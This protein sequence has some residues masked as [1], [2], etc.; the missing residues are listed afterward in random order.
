MIKVII[1]NKFN[2]I[3]KR[4]LIIAIIITNT[5]VY[6]PS[7]SIAASDDNDQKV[8][9][10]V[11]AAANAIISKFV[12]TKIT[13]SKA[14]AGSMIT[15]NSDTGD[16]WDS[17]TKVTSSNGTTR[18]YRNYKQYNN[19]NSYWNNWYW[20]GNISSDGCGPSSVAIVLSGY[21]YDYNP[22]DV[23]EV[24][25]SVFKTNA[26]NTFEKLMDPLKHIGNIEAEAH[27]GVGTST[28]IDIIRENFKAGRPVIVNAPGHYV[29]YLGEDANG[30]LI[31]SDPGAHDGGHARYGVTLEDLINNGNITNGYILIKSDGSATT[32]KPSSTQSTNNSNSTKEVLRWPVGSEQ[33]TTQGGKTFANGTPALGTGNVSRGGMSRGWSNEDH[34]KNGGQALDIHSNGSSNV[35]NVVAMANGKVIECGDGIADGDKEGHGGMGNYVTIDYGNG[36]EIRAMH[37]YIGTISVKTGDTVQAGQVLGKIGHSGDSS[38]AHL[39]L[40]MKKD[41]QWVD[42]SQYIAEPGVTVNSN[43][44]ATS[45]MSN[46]NMS[47]NI[48]KIEDSG[49]SGYKINIDLDKEIDDMLAKLKKKNFK[50]DSY[51]SSSKQKEYLKNMVK[52][53]IVTQYPDLRSASEIANKNSKI[54]DDE[55]QGCIKIKRYADGETEAFGGNIL[56]KTKDSQDGGIYLE[57]RPYDDF[58]KLINNG[59]RAALNYF[60]LDSSNNIVVAGWETMD[61]EISEPVQTNVDEVGAAPSTYNEK[62]VPKSNEYTKLTMKNVNYL[63]QVSNYTMPFSL[64]WSLLVYGHDENFANDVAKLVID[65]EI[66]I[67]CYDATDIRI[68]NYDITYSKV[69]IVQSTAYMPDVTSNT[70]HASTTQELPTVEVEYK[71]KA[72]EKDTLKTDNPALKVTYADTWTAVYKYDYK[73]EATTKNPDKQEVLHKDETLETNYYQYRD[74]Q[75]TGDRKPKNETVKSKLD[76][77]IEQESDQIISKQ[78]ES[79][80]KS[81]ESYNQQYEYR[82]TYIGKVIDHYYS[83]GFINGYAYS[84]LQKKEVQSY[85]INMILDRGY[86]NSVFTNENEEILKYAKEIS[87]NDYA[88]CLAEAEEAVKMILDVSSTEYDPEDETLGAGIYKEI[89]KQG[90]NRQ[91]TYNAEITSIQIAERKEKINQ[92][93]EITQ[94]ITTVEVKGIPN[95]NDNLRWKDNKNAKENSFVKILAHSKS[96]RSNLKIIDTWFF[97]SV[98]ETAAIADLSDLIRFLFEC[99]YNKDYGVSPERIEELKD[100][101]DPTK[102]QTA[103]ITISGN[104]VQEKVWNALIQAGCNEIVT[105]G[106]MGNIQEESS[107]ITN[108]LQ[109]SYEGGLGSDEEYTNK[110]N[111]GTYSKNSFCNDKAGYGLAQWTSAGRKEGLYD[112]AKAK[113]VSIDD[114]DM[115][116]EYLLTEMGLSEAASTFASKITGRNV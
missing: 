85:V 3:I 92:K 4:I 30:K 101:F 109:D 24:M 66:V 84:L 75:Y 87:G 5:F 47:G 72:S 49:R 28:D 13:N 36:I 59:D 58:T 76:Q 41:G 80:R 67:G 46:V 9:A 100:L 15:D 79:L 17:V 6:I 52:A 73:L 23:V 65:T 18:T 105:A 81:V 98:S 42:I 99:V 50:M 55:V 83:Q 68:Y 1:N 54:P 12:S 35:Y 71:F 112:Y 45:T 91:K 8:P 111:N 103:S 108:N 10:T 115:Q 102:F 22:G 60:T 64:L 21:G 113:G 90:S 56:S 97:E 2:N 34:E 89:T 93:E 26:S 61:V 63:S 44:T 110:V 96:A 31:I 62:I 40:D 74:N 57:Y 116:I 27:Y 20:E 86:N 69:E 37:M 11:P 14:T 19:G 29:V 70:P 48:T 94:E 38:G 25:H 77:T 104:T 106:A 43:N 107:F 39:H 7:R 33:T 78:I 82:Y 88:I 95:Q 32:N 16:G 114:V 51:L 53:S